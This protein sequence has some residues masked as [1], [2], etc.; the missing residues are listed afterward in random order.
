MDMWRYRK[1]QYIPAEI[2]NTFHRWCQSYGSWKSTPWTYRRHRQMW[3]SITVTHT[4]KLWWLKYH[5]SPNLP[6]HNQR[7]EK[8]NAS[9]CDDGTFDAL[10]S[11]HQ[12]FP[13]VHVGKTRF[14]ST[15]NK[16]QATA[17]L[18]KSLGRGT[19]GISE[20]GFRS[21]ASE[22]HTHTLFSFLNLLS[23]GYIVLLSLEPRKAL[24]RDLLCTAHCIWNG[25]H[26]W[27]RLPMRLGLTLANAIKKLNQHIEQVCG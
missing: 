2:T 11:Y 6:R 9:S 25:C 26:T 12:A 22:G 20:T 17:N 27:T 5:G 15:K 14:G 24:T 3:S 10:T 23:S 19:H 8:V 1:Q 16:W 18:E 21:R 4:A 7:S 13:F